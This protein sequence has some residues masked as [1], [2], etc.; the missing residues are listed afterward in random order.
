MHTGSH[1]CAR[2]HDAFFVFVKLAVDA[3]KT[4]LERPVKSYGI[5]IYCIS[6]R[7]NS[8]PCRCTPI[9]Y[10]AFSKNL[11]FMIIF[12]VH[13]SDGSDNTETVLRTI[14]TMVGLNPNH[15]AKRWRWIK[16]SLGF[17]CIYSQFDE[18]KNASCWQHEHWEPVYVHPDGESSFGVYRERAF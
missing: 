5:W 16:N 13:A 3:T 14:L 4:V 11:S 2:Q 15:N 12:H 8:S 6:G 7:T 18:G 17:F 9:K 1:T 10:T